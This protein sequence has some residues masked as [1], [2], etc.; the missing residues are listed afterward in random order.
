[1]TEVFQ[2]AAAVWTARE[3]GG[4]IEEIVSVESVGTT[5]VRVAPNDAERVVLLLVNMSTNLMYVGFDEEVSQNRGIFLSPN[6]G[7]YE[8]DVRTDFMVQSY[9][10]Y[11]ISVGAS[12]NLYVFKLRRFSKV[13]DEEV[14]DETF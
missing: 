6:G 3:I 13:T 1:M 4:R 7:S 8:V 10:H 5:P 12:S 11:A 9:A 2:G 14:N